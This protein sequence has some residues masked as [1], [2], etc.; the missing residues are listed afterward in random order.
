MNEEKSIIAFENLRNFRPKET[1]F[2]AKMLRKGPG[3]IELMEMMEKQRINNSMVLLY[4]YIRW[5]YYI[6][7][8][9]N[10]IVI[11]V[12]VKHKIDSKSLMY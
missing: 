5:Y 7:I 6:I 4:Y 10:G 2:E 8:I 9:F 11:F 1:I 12:L 3:R